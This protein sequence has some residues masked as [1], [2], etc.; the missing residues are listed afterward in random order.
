MLSYS[1]A[2]DTCMFPGISEEAMMLISI[3][4]LQLPTQSSSIKILQRS[5][6][7]N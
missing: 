4:K 1:R 7:Q 5:L 3:F 6:S 2:Q